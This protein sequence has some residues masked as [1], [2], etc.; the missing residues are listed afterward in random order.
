MNILILGGSGYVGSAV[1]ERLRTKHSVTNVDLNWFDSFVP[2][3]KIDYN[4][5]SRAYINAFDVVILLAGHSSVKMCEDNLHSAYRN[6][7]YNFINLIE[8]IKPEQKFIY[9]SSASVYGATPL[10]NLKESDTNFT[11]LNPYDMT[12][13]HIDQIAE[14]SGCEYY[15]LRFGTINGAA[16]HWRTDV[17]IN[18]MTHTALEQRC[19][20][21]FNGDVKRSILGVTDAV[22]A[23]E[24]IVEGADHRGI[25][26]LASFTMTARQIAK[27]VASIVGVTLLETEPEQNTN[28]KLCTKTYDFG[29]DTHKFTHTYNYEFTQ[30]VESITKGLI[31]EYTN[32]QK[33]HRNCKIHYP[34]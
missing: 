20:K 31:N 26:N 28:A 14:H 33:S 30:T 22:N 5:L 17:M 29:M 13:L 32:T 2:S 7:V 9:A 18:A 11:P 19:V 16:P 6:N 21:L 8:K 24:L 1:Y 34:G 4:T 3:S 25:Y 23:I 27:L 15:G 12:K 10:D